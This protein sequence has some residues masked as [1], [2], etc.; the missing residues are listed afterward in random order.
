VELADAWWAGGGYRATSPHVL[1]RQRALIELARRGA[2]NLGRHIG[3]DDLDLEIV[4]GLLHDGILRL[5]RAGHA[6]RFAHDIFFEWSFLHLLTGREEDWLAAIR[7]AGEPP[8][9]GRPV[10]LLSQRTFAAD[11]GWEERLALLEAATLRP[12]WERAW[13]LGPVGAA[14][15]GDRAAG[16]V[17]AVFRDDARC[18]GKLAV[19]FQAEKTRPNPLI[20]RGAG[21]SA[22]GSPWE[23]MQA[24]DA[25]AVPSDYWAWSRC[26]SWLLDHFDRCPVGTIPDV[27]SVFEVWQNA[28]AHR[29]NEVSPR[30]V[31]IAH[32]WLEEIEDGLDSAQPR[33]DRG[34]WHALRGE[35]LDELEERLRMLVLR[36]ARADAARVGCYL[37]RLRPRGLLR[38]RAFRQVLLFA[39][40]L[41][42]THPGELVE[43]TLNELRDELPA[44][45]VARA[46]SRGV[47]F[48][49]HLYD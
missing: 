24:A 31:A 20:L 37:A 26:C 17:E 4:E 2:A 38:S 3:L 16:F 7:E 29:P 18:L 39:P 42:S 32:G 19:W 1:R 21:P 40:L 48:G 22:G 13:L 44:D 12:Q 45:T 28:L 35:E 23:T 8:A 5:A 14:N 27:V 15:F 10:E 34:R 25:W 46:P 6:V 9:L 49:N 36:S 11:E 33:S 47:S 30:I 41:A 43:L